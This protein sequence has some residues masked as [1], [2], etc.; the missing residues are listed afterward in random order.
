LL[1]TNGDESFS[2]N[3]LQINTGT[4]ISGRFST[5]F[6]PRVWN[7]R[8]H[9]TPTVLSPAPT[10]SSVPS[11]T[12]SVSI[13]P[14]S[15]PTEFCPTGLKA[16]VEVFTDNYPG[17]T[18]WDIKDVDGAVVASRNSYTSGSTLYEDKVCLPETAACSGT[19]YTFTINDTYGDGICCSYGIGSYKVSIEDEIY[20]EGGEFGSSESKSLCYLPGTE[21]SGT[22][23]VSVKPSIVPS[24]APSNTPSVSISPS[25]TP[26]SAPS[27]AP[28]VSIA[29]SSTPSEFCPTGL[30]AKVE[31][32]TD[33]WPGETSWDI[34]DADD[35]VVAS[36]NSYT[37]PDTPYEDSVC[38]LETESCSGTDYTFT[39][40]DTYGDGICCGW[41]AGSYTVSIEDEIYAEG[42]DFGYS[43]SKSL[44][45]LPG[46]EPSG[47]PTVSAK[48]SI[49]PSQAP[50]NTPS[51]SISPSSTPTSVP[52][53]TPSVSISPSSTPSEFCPGG[54]GAKVEIFTDSWAYET[55]W[56]IKDADG[57][58]VASRNSFELAETLYENSVC[59]PETESCSGTDYTFTISDTYGDGICCAWGPG[60]YKVTVEEVIHADDL[61]R[62]G[63]SYS[64]SLCYP[65][66]STNGSENECDEV[67][68]RNCYWDAR[69]GECHECSSISATPFPSTHRRK[70]NYHGCSWN[71]NS[72]E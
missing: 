70:C 30:K 62:S 61:F 53:N 29:P 65:S 69:N 45:F 27:N 51:V 1:Y 66:C 38:L 32:F 72:C 10:L 39:I 2:D 41:G 26:S 25:S 33:N 67:D 37:S 55:S 48:P 21:P 56:D 63:L 14:S 17:E 36:R 7:G 5:T 43:E 31:V 6:Y 46:T 12:P 24:Q 23:T 57:A 49:V 9:Y 42:G 28:S 16:K 19:D 68:T 60:S 44:C 3:Y 8:I 4:G 15:T 52:S 54:I 64:T 50:S 58:V 35:V 40:S 18:S 20:A 71:G 22:P 13:S 34:K 47:T 11:N 59:L